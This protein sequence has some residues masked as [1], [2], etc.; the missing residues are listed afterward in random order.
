MFEEV[1]ARAAISQ[2]EDFPK[3]PAKMLSGV[4]HQRAKL[5]NYFTKECEFH[6]ESARKVGRSQ[7]QSARVRAAAGLGAKSIMLM[8]PTTQETTLPPAAMEFAA[9]YR[10]GTFSTEDI[11]V[12]VCGKC[13]PSI[14]H[15]LSCKYLRGRF[16][17]HDVIVNILHDM[18]SEVGYCATTEMMVVEHSQKRMDIVVTLPTGV[19][20]L[21]VSVVNPLVETYLDDTNHLKTR[22]KQKIAKYATHASGANARFVP[23]IVDTFGAIGKQAAEFLKLIAQKGWDNRVI[24]ATSSMEHAV[25]QYRWRLVQRLGAAIAHT[26]SSMVEE[27]RVRATHHHASTR[28]IYAAAR[29]KSKRSAATKGAS[30]APANAKGK[31]QASAAHAWSRARRFQPAAQSGD[32]GGMSSGEQGAER[33]EDRRG[34]EGAGGKKRRREAELSREMEDVFGAEEEEVMREEG[35]GWSI[36]GSPLVGIFATVVSDA[37]L[38]ASSL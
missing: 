1:E 14:T 33:R 18:L 23:F 30:K 3:S 31:G 7:L 35:G 11:K 32:S 15:I 16:I 6:I 13:T 17:R 8:Q 27:V 29:A 10:S 25:G 12:C 5:Q 20:W 37:D 4:I 36:G 22:E 9:K 19:V 2:V 26:N 24:A 21:D 28:V 38:G 34:D